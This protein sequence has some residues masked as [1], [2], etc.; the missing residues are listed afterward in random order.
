MVDLKDRISKPRGLKG[1]PTYSY[2]NK[3]SGVAFLCIWGF[4]LT[5][6]YFYLRDKN[7]HFFTPEELRQRS[8][9]KWLEGYI[10]SKKFAGKQKERALQD[11]KWYPD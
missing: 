11:Q 8:D 2:V 3:A 6:A 5:L 9:E 7:I 4:S 1:T 10:E